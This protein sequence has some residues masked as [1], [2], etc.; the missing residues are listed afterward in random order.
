MP[1]LDVDIKA[2]KKLYDV[3]VWGLLATTQAFVPLLI[4]AK[5][6]I[7]NIGST[8]GTLALPYRGIYTSSKAAVHLMTDTLR[9]ELK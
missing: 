6:T 2:A 9:I 8:A 1:L 5:G 7:V 4:T 3:N